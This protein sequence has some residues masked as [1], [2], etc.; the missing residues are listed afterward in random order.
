MPI[1]ETLGQVLQ[2]WADF[3]SHA[4]AVQAGVEFL[5]VGALLTGG[6]LAVASDRAALRALRAPPETQR[7][8]LAE[9]TQVH[10]PV[11]IALAVAGCS[12]L[13]MLASDIGTFAASPV[14][15]TKMSLV[16]LLLGNGYLVKRNGERLD[17]DPAPGNPAW[18]RLRFGAIASIT[19]W[20]ATTLAGVILLN[21]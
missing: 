4:K 6:G 20:L 14:F 11:L 19:L 15:W 17:A 8:V 12:G 10:R 13:L 21:S 7:F 3:Y 16:A 2:P 9:L 1:A 18:P 5:H